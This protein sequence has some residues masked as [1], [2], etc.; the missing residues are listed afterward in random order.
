MNIVVRRAL[1]EKREKKYSQQHIT[2]NKRKS[3]NSSSEATKQYATA[4][5]MQ[6]SEQKN[7]MEYSP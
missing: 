2:D 4:Q 5:R 7:W 6:K 1:D 3:R